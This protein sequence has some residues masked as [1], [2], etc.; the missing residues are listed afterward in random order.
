MDIPFPTPK[1]EVSKGLY[2]SSFDEVPY[3]KNRYWH[4]TCLIGINVDHATAFCIST[5][6][7]KRVSQGFSCGAERSRSL[8]A[9]RIELEWLWRGLFQQ[10]VANVPLV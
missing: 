10:F 5:L 8:E 7:N 9:E 4:R 6:L 2:L 3:S 1:T